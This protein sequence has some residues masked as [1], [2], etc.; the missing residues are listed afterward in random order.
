MT[1][2]VGL[3]GTARV[4]FPARSLMWSRSR[5]RGYPGDQ[6]PCSWGGTESGHS[7]PCLRKSAYIKRH[8]ADCRVGDSGIIS[9]LSVGPNA[10]ESMSHKPG[11]AGTA[12]TSLRGSAYPSAAIKWVRDRLLKAGWGTHLCQRLWPTNVKFPNTRTERLNSRGPL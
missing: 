4:R 2:C 11:E 1:Y 10:I 6:G 9:K 3:A 5:W 7:Q 12:E 8:K